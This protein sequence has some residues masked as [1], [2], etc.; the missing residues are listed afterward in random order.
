MGTSLALRMAPVIKPRTMSMLSRRCRRGDMG[1]AAEA[2]V[3][4]VT[5]ERE[6]LRGVTGN[7]TPAP[8]SAMLPM[9]S[10]SMRA[11]D[12]DVPWL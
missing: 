3:G 4:E 6:P 2:E 9:P 7:E 11:D 10:L 1:A 5:L 12:G 8:F